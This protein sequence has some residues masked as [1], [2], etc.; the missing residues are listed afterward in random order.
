MKFIDFI[1]EQPCCMCGYPTAHPHHLPQKNKSRHVNDDY[2]VPLCGLC[3][4]NVHQNPKHEKKIL[5][6]LIY[7]AKK[8]KKEFDNSCL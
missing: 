7:F 1:R 2:C 3:H 8:M 5:L 6:K 4:Y